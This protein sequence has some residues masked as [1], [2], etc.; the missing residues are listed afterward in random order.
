MMMLQ[1]GE[2]WHRQGLFMGMHWAWWTFWILAAAVVLWAFWRVYSDE[3]EARGEVRAFRNREADL[4]A[5]HE[6][7]E[8]SR[9]QLID[10]L[11]AMFGVPSPRS[12]PGA[13]A[14]PTDTGGRR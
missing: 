3:R 10:E 2:T 12:G 8:I 6:R 4:R 5:R 14:Q 1:M 7:G 9:E 11:G 13:T